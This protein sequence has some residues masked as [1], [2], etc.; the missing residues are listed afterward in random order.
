MHGLK[1]AKQQNKDTKMAAKQETN[2]TEALSLAR[3]DETLHLAVDL[4]KFIKEN[5]LFQNFAGK[6]Y[7]NVEGWQYAGSRLG[8]VPLV[9]EVTNT[10]TDTEL[11]YQAR[12]EL[13]NL[14]SGQIVGTGFAVCSSK[15]PGKRNYQEFAIASMAQTRAIGKAYRNLLA[16]IIRAAG[17][18]PT[19]AEEMDYAGNTVAP[20]AER[21]TVVVEEEGEVKTATAKQ[22]AEIIKLLNHPVISNDEKNKMI[23][24]INRFDEE[25]AVQAIAKLK[26][27]IK[28]RESLP[29]FSAQISHANEVNQAVQE[30]AVPHERA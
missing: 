2:Q 20:A 7:V 3:P 1:K 13:L 10:S 6:E 22:K 14:T 25:R 15:E 23:L 29:E 24:N 12:V 27:T 5:K 28:D 17:Y 16:W 4:T 21:N 11:K 19:P 26:K 30:G 9:R 18:E 8:L